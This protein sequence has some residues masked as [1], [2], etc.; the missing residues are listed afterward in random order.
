MKSLNR[1]HGILINL[2]K[3]A[4]ICF[5]TKCIYSL[6]KIYLLIDLLGPFDGFYSVKGSILPPILS[7]DMI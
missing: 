5:S 3:W 6:P 1:L 2:L 4:S 7:L